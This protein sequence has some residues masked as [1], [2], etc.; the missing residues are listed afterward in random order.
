MNKREF[1]VH[2]L[3]SKIYQDQFVTKKLPTEREL[4]IQYNVS[5]YT[6]HEA[7]N[8]LRNMGIVKVV[9]GSGIF[10][11]KNIKTSPLVYNSLTETHYSK[12]TSKVIS[13]E[14]QLP[15]KEFQQIFDIKASD[16]IW[17]FCR[18]RII[19]Y[20]IMQI[21]YSKLPVHLF[22]NLAKGDIEKSIQSYVKKQKLQISHYF[23]T[24]ESIILDKEQAELLQQKKKTPAMKI[25]SRGILT[26]GKVFVASENIAL[27]YKCTYITAFNKEHHSLRQL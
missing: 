16:E 2:D 8:R 27:D 25:S 20:Q 23:N 24:Y 6:I 13:F 9:Q 12:I 19:N 17:S 5:R 21:E 15:T 26:E 22:P 7:I 10:I 1:I 18:L 4:A 3:L 14:K 11:G